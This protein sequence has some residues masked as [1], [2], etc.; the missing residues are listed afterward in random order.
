[1]KPIAFEK[2]SVADAKRSLDGIPRALAA[3]DDWT[4]RRTDTQSEPLREASAAWMLTLPEGVR[5][6]QLA[7]RFARI[8]NRIH[9]LWDQDDAV[10][11]TR[12]LADLMISRRGNRQGFPFAIAMEI[13]RLAVHH[14]E[15]NPVGRGWA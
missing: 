1:M 2:V 14:A 8:V 3:H 13:D 7:G 15:L 9:A 5:P 12:Y 10:P 4:S 6:V 11:C